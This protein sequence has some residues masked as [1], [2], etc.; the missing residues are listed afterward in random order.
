MDYWCA[1]WFQ[2]V[3]DAAE[4]PT[5]EEWYTDLVQILN[6]DLEQATTLVAE[7]DD[8]VRDYR[9]DKNRL[10]SSSPRHCANLTIHSLRTKGNFGTSL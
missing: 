1:L 9:R 6:I 10:R 3:R 7:D 8:A 4:L 2:D 5:R